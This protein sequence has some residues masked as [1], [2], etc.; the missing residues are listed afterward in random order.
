MGQAALL[1]DHDVALARA[2]Q[3][4]GDRA[5]ENAAAEDEDFGMARGGGWLG[6][7]GWLLKA[8]LAAR[9]HTSSQEFQH[10]NQ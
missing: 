9:N 7:V 2:R 8:F 1:Q 10:E 5:A 4:I 6:H 3:V